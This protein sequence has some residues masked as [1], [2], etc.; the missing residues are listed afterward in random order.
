MNRPLKYPDSTTSR[1]VF[2]IS[3]T[4]PGVQD[5]WRICDA[6]A[7][8]LNPR[9]QWKATETFVLRGYT[10]EPDTPFRGD[11]VSEPGYTGRLDVGCIVRVKRSVITPRDGWGEVTHASTGRIDSI[12]GRNECRLSFFEHNRPWS[13]HLDEL[14]LVNVTEGPYALCF[15][16]IPNRL[17]QPPPVRRQP[18]PLVD[19]RYDGTDSMPGERPTWTSH[20]SMARFFEEAGEQEAADAYRREHGLSRAPMSVP[21]PRKRKADESGTAVMVVRVARRPSGEPEKAPTS[22]ICAVCMERPISTVFIGCGCACL[23]NT[24]ADATGDACPMC[25]VES[26]TIKFRVQGTALA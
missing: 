11:E 8:P 17:T 20:E 12:R 26:T 5:I 16:A 6:H 13:G 18:S 2:M 24:C 19:D 1:D 7:R 15:G 23:C 3:T 4:D 14:V 9:R 21:Y 22:E 10:I 25:R